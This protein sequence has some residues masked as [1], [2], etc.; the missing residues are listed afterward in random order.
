[1]RFHRGKIKH[2]FTFVFIIQFFLVNTLPAFALFGGP[3]IP[4]PSSVLSDVEKRYHLDT[5]SIQNIGEAMNVSS[6]KMTVPEVSIFFTPSDPKEGEKITAKAFPTFFSNSEE[7]MYYT[8]S[9]KRNGCD[10]EKSY[11]RN[12]PQKRSCDADNNG[13]IDVEDW[14]I[15]AGRILVQNGYD[16]TDNADLGPLDD[17]GYRAHFGGA[18]RTTASNEYCYINDPSSGT[19]YELASG[20]SETR[21]I[22]SYGSLCTGNRTPACAVEE[23]TLENT[24]LTMNTSATGGSSSATGGSGDANGGTGGSAS[25]TNASAS[26]N[27]SGDVVKT[28]QTGYTVSGI[29]ACFNNTI[30]C[31]IGT[32]KCVTNINSSSPIYGSNLIS[33]SSTADVSG[34]IT[35]KCQHLFP[36]AS[37][38]GDNR[39][40]EREEGFWGTNPRDPSTADNG[41]KD[42]ANV[43]GLGQSSFTWT[44]QKGDKIGVAVEGTSLVPT[45]HDNTSFMTM[46]AFSNKKCNP[47]GT[48]G[49]YSQMIKGYSVSFP[50]V[51]MDLNDCI[52]RSLVDPTVGGQ[53]TRLTLAV[54]ATPDDPINDSSDDKSGDT[55]F[56][57]ASVDNA[58]KNIANILFDWKIDIARNISDFENENSQPIT[59][60]LIDKKLIGNI[61][62]NGLDSLQLKMNLTNEDINNIEDY[63]YLRFRVTAVESFGENQRR[64]GTSDIVVKF[65]NSTDKISVKR[66]E[67]DDQGKVR[68]ITDDTLCDGHDNDLDKT[69]CKVIKNEI[70]GLKVDSSNLQNFRWTINGVPL[71]CNSRVSSP[72]D[73]KA[74]GAINFFPVT[75]NPGD[76]YTVTMT[77]N[78]VSPSGSITDKTVTLTRAFVVVE[79]SVTL[80]STNEENGAWRKFLGRY[81]SL[82]DVVGNSECLENLCDDFSDSIYEAYKGTTGVSFYADF[83]P[84]FL[85]RKATVTFTLDGMDTS[86]QDFLD[87]KKITPFDITK[88]V[89]ETYTIGVKAEVAEDVNLRKALMNIWGI[90]P[91]S[92]SELHFD[93]S[94]QLEVKDEPV[95][96]GP[97]NGPRKYY[98]AIASYLP[99]SVLFTFRIFLS[100]VLVLFTLHL[101]NRMLENRRLTAFVNDAVEKEKE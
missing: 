67:A 42:E 66:V 79:P 75:G 53:A 30:I 63:K 9:L 86:S 97:M 18:N 46:W 59:D 101:L 43:V 7:D 96:E 24:T 27:A 25:A 95:T 11:D 78:E 38:S 87:S 13:N 99:S 65:I 41:N 68:L 32:P 21:F 55:I 20:S 2:F 19:N 28:S 98:A 31:N 48:T 76:M 74:Q 5:G 80:K 15:T 82:V 62:G 61:K 33:C 51:D 23:L 69:L 83:T 47:S 35:N 6:G 85:G 56:V 81:K 64:K 39:F 73:D 44:Y 89:G 90:S 37:E 17:D 72:C 36:R 71:L 57:Q 4:S 60:D 34:A 94:V 77:A 49:S 29:P 70:I 1:M 88:A 93:S 45:K 52:P 16:T 22:D 84:N 8:W 26:A 10:I 40:E 50:T 14:K 92:S 3:K 54:S 91:F 100:A 12:D 58:N